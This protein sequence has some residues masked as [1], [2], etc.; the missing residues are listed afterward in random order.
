MKS[1]DK[2]RVIVDYRNITHEQLEFLSKEYPYG[3]DEDDIFSYKNAKGEIVD[4]IPL[5]TKDTKYLFKISTHLES[6]LQAFQDENES[7]DELEID[8]DVSEIPEEDIDD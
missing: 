7:D 5:E 2:K 3:I 4:A 8:E 1:A 6:K